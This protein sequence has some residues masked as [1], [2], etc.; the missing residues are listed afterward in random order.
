MKST[1]NSNMIPRGRVRS[2][3]KMNRAFVERERTSLR[4]RIKNSK[5]TEVL[6]TLC[7]IDN[8]LLG[9]KHTE[10]YPIIIGRKLNRPVDGK[11]IK[12]V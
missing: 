9:V 8:A 2:D 5:V 7:C 10:H 4:D 3:E 1:A 6:V 12:Y 11:I